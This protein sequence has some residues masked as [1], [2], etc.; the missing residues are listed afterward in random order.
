MLPLCPFPIGSPPRKCERT[1]KAQIRLGLDLHAHCEQQ[2]KQI[3]VGA[4]LKSYGLAQKEDAAT[5]EP[6][7]F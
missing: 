4:L 2:A 7:F 3:W 6:S 1:E 5:S